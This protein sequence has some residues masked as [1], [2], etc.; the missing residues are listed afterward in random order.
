MKTHT[1]FALLAVLAVSPAFS[2]P[3]TVTTPT[4]SLAVP[5][6]LASLIVPAV[7]PSA[8][9]IQAVYQTPQA[10][11]T[12]AVTQDVNMTRTIHSPY[13]TAGGMSNY[14]NI[15]SY[16]AANNAGD[17]HMNILDVNNTQSTYTD[18]SSGNTTTDVNA[19][20]ASGGIA[21]LGSL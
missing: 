11:T 18:T 20:A 6:G 3:F 14:N 4:A 7:V 15:S 5:A 2:A 16:A 19:M 21:T 8:N 17:A 9:K 10:N 12:S 1:K 13:G